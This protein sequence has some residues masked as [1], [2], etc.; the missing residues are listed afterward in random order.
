MQ[1]RKKDE[2]A[3]DDDVDLCSRVWTLP[4]S[5]LNSVDLDIVFT[6]AEFARVDHGVVY[7]EQRKPKKGE[8]I[9]GVHQGGK[10]FGKRGRQRRGEGAF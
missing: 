10:K 9:C 2:A 1:T 7:T 6:C 4:K 5:L 3:K 8:S